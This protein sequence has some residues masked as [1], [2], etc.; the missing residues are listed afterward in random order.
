M[1]RSDSITVRLLLVGQMA[2]TKVSLEE[3]LNAAYRPEVEYIDGKL[4]ET[5]PLV[6][7]EVVYPEDPR[8]ARVGTA[9]AEIG[10]RLQYF[11]WRI[12]RFIST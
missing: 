7:V 4:Q 3:Y 1:M 11:G 6:A 5:A 2:T 12:R 10:L 9:P 8:L